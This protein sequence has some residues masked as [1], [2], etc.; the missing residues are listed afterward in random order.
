MKHASWCLMMILLIAPSLLQAQQDTSSLGAIFFS[1]ISNGGDHAG[2]FFTAPLHFSEKDWI[3][4]G[5]IVAGTAVLF[6]VDEHA[7]S[8]AER[9]HSHWGDNF[10]EVGNQY[11]RAIYG[12]TLSSG[13]YV[14]G[15]IARNK[16]VRET[17]MMVFE[18]I[19]FAGITT[20]VLKTLIGRSRPYIEDGPRSFH[21]FE[22]NVDK[23][24]LPSGHSTVAFA[25][26][27]VLAERI[28]NSYA[29]V[30]LYTFAVITAAARVYDDEHWF[31]DTLFGAV[32]GTVS[33]LAVTRY[34]DGEKQHASI[35]LIPM[36][37][38]VR[39]EVVF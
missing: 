33:G 24:S 16:D 37:G 25:F 18:S 11:G 23:T 28:G 1:D 29:T 36:L 9:N 13:L 35:R 5:A 19:A 2:S 7:R 30:G 31:S 34:H 10:A 6:S 26:S 27:S 39:A 15:L 3:I 22:F 4:T 17:G 32:I 20:T 8:L 38:G 21:P 14:G 12:I